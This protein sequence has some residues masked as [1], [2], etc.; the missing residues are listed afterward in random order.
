M[1][2]L[3][4]NPPFILMFVGGFGSDML[5]HTRESSFLV[6]SYPLT[7]PAN[8]PSMDLVAAAITPDNS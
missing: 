4:P 3:D 6:L 2:L 7:D 8:M 5:D 1:S